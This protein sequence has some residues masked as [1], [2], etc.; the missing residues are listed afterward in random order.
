MGIIE[1]LNKNGHTILMITHAMETAALY[2]NKIMA[3][4]EGKVI[5]YGDKRKFFSD[6]SLLETSKITRTEIMDLSLKLNSRLLLNEN[7]FIQ[8]WRKK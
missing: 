4:N 2:G 1:G 3:L 7:E 6:E 5:F 8:C